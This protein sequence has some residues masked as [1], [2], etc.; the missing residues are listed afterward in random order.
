MGGRSSSSSSSSSSQKSIDARVGATEGAQVISLPEGRIDG[1]VSISTY[2]VQTDQGLVS[3]SRDVVSQALATVGENSQGGF[4][5][6]N[7]IAGDVGDL[8]ESSHALV[9]SSLSLGDRAFDFVEVAREQQSQADKEQQE[10]IVSQVIEAL[11]L[12][13]VVGGGAFAASR[14]WGR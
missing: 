2:E 3:L 5:L 14:I 1:N 8:V 6:L 12:I 7:A 4:E 9:D 13:A 11:V 10:R